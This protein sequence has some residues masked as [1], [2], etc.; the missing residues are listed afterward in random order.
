M[1]TFRSFVYSAHESFKISFFY[2]RLP[3]QVFNLES[4]FFF[5]CPIMHSKIQSSSQIGG[6]FIKMILDENSLRKNLFSLSI[7]VQSKWA[8]AARNVGLGSGFRKK[9]L[10]WSK[11]CFWVIRPR[12]I[13]HRVRDQFYFGLPFLFLF[14]FFSYLPSSIKHLITYS[15]R[16]D[17]SSPLPPNVEGDPWSGYRKEFIRLKKG[18]Y[19]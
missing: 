3:F 8:F 11:L 10:S 13:F 16:G 14:I 9:K 4:H 12:I 1:L 17:F 7:H 2:S 5:D 15:S 18:D 19:G 6:S